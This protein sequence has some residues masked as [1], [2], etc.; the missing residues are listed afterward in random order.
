MFADEAEDESEKN[1][2]RQG[3]VCLVFSLQRSTTTS[4][5]RGTTVSPSA[6]T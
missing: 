3:G 4:G 1:S 2:Q 5:V 6:D